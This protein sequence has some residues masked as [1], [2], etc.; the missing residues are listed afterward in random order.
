MHDS[1]PEVDIRIQ[2]PEANSQ[3]GA[4]KHRNISYM[5]CVQYVY[6]VLKR[7]PGPIG[8]ARMRLKRPWPPES[9]VPSFLLVF[10]INFQLLENKRKKQLDSKR[11]QWLMTSLTGPSRNKFLAALLPRP[12]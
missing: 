3:K 6:V 5:S 4:P 2:G 8:A 10:Y 12:L 11:C 7:I 1:Q 9:N